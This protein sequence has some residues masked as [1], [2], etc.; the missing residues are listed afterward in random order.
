MLILHSCATTDPRCRSGVRKRSESAAAQREQRNLEFGERDRHGRCPG[1][2]VD[3][4]K[5]RP[6]T[7]TRVKELPFGQS[8]QLDFGMEL[9]GV[10][11]LLDY[12]TLRYLHLLL[13]G[14]LRSAR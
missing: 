7:E 14:T 6:W 10:S 13:Q 2:P 9:Q 5:M 3:Y 11:W 12:P 8:V 1:S 4:Q